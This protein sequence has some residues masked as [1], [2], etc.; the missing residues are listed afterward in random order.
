MM[1]ITNH[2]YYLDQGFSNVA[3]LIFLKISLFFNWRKI[4][5]IDILDWRDSL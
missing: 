4:A 5:V 3:L 1:L 2:A